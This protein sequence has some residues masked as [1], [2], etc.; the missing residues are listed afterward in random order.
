MSFGFLVFGIVLYLMCQR[1]PFFGFVVMGVLP[2]VVLG[3]LLYVFWTGQMWFY[4]GLWCL[5]VFVVLPF[6]IWV[7]RRVLF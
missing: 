1:F 7:Q 6:G 4:V 5:M 3:V 2:V